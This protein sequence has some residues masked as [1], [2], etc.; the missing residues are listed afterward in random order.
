MPTRT[1]WLCCDGDIYMYKLSMN[2]KQSLTIAF[3]NASTWSVILT[4]QIA[5]TCQILSKSRDT[6]IMGCD[7]IFSTTHYCPRCTKKGNARMEAALLHRDPRHQRNQEDIAKTN[8]VC[9]ALDM[10][11]KANAHACF[12]IKNLQARPKR[13]QQGESLTSNEH[14]SYAL[15]RQLSMPPLARSEARS[16]PILARM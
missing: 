1:R 6:Q 5:P 3:L 2:A 8:R 10:C 15:Q 12:K 9:C 4:S 7:C 13:R 11:A 14:C 16:R